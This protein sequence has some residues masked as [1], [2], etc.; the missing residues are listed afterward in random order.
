MRVE[1]LHPEYSKP[2]V[3]SR[4]QGIWECAERAPILDQAAP[5][6]VHR[7]REAGPS[8]EQFPGEAN[9]RF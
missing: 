2:I 4:V 9:V 6:D 1:F 8:E 3:T 7:T 5:E